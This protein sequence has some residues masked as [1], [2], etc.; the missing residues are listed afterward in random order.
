MSTWLPPSLRL[1]LFGLLAT[2]SLCL[3]DWN[4]MMLLVPPRGHFALPWEG[5]PSRLG[6]TLQHVEVSDTQGVAFK[7]SSGEAAALS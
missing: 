5:I 6:G 2:R 1:L 4:R 3:W 7:I